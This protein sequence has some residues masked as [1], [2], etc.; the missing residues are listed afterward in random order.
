MQKSKA[1]DPKKKLISQ[2][3]YYSV[4]YYFFRNRYPYIKHPY[5]VLQE[6][7]NLA[8]WQMHLSRKW[9]GLRCTISKLLGIILGCE[10]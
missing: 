2:F 9:K 6:W 3:I 5:R 10:I 8:K 7:W 4:I 1:T